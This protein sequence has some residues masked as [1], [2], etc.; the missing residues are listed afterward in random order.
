MKKRILSQ[1]LIPAFILGILSGLSSAMIT[2]SNIRTFVISN[3]Y[4]HVDWGTY[5]QYKSATHAH[6][7]NSDGNNTLASVAERHYELGFHILA[8]TD[9]DVTFTTPDKAEIGAMTSER[10]KEMQNGAGRNGADG[11][12]FIP[13]ANE[14]S[15][16]LSTA[17][18]PRRGQH[19]STY[20]SN[21]QNGGI[22][23][24]LVESMLERLRTEGTGIAR[25]NHI[26]RNTLAAFVASDPN[27]QALNFADAAAKNST[28][29]YVEHYAGLFKNNPNLVG[30]EIINEFDNESQASEIMWDNILTRLMPEGRNVWGFSA[31]DSHTNNNVGWSYDIM[32]MPELSLSELRYAKESGA[33]FGFSR[34]NR[35]YDIYA[36]AIIPEDTRGSS[37]NINRIRET[38][39]LPTP[40]INSITTGINTITINAANYEFINWYSDGILIHSGPT[41]DFASL[42][43]NS[44][45]FGSYVRATVGHSDY[46]VLFTQ[47]FG[48]RES[49][50][51][52]PLPTAQ[53]ITPPSSANITLPWGTNPDEMSLQL[54]G[55][56]SITTTDGI[57]RPAAIIWNLNSINYNPANKSAQTFTITGTVK[58]TGINI[59][60][61]LS[62]NVSVQ[63]TV[64]AYVGL[65]E[66]N[67]QN[68]P[69]LHQFAGSGSSGNST[70]AL[71]GSNSGTRTVNMNSQPRTINITSRGGTSQ[72][73]D[74]KLFALDTTPGYSYKFEFTGRVTSGSGNQNIF[75]NAVSGDSGGGTNVS[76]L[77]SISTAVNSTFT[78]SHSSTHEEIQSYLS[79]ATPVMRYRLGGASSQDLEITGIV[80]TEF[81]TPFIPPTYTVTWNRDG[82]EPAPTQTSVFHGGSIALP[83]AMNRAGYI[84]DGWFMDSGFN[85]VAVF[86]ITNVTNDTTL[87]AKWSRIAVSF[88]RNGTGAVVSPES[89]FVN[90]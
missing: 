69:N 62:P 86:P 76:T 25:L 70:H 5:N 88:N 4:A 20:W 52:L 24:E 18:I 59:P 16:R 27:Q 35:R 3:P 43:N 14:R 51:E 61:N 60:T 8:Y 42:Q 21:I 78:I 17:A 11:M 73:L 66:Y 13:G 6:T 47:P 19:V 80:I 49:G 67:M 90:A 40:Q 29:A 48:I 77:A 81:L 28:Q 55:G 75:I 63:R 7:T 58:P 45:N 36:G 87:W 46:G 34:V 53:I 33:F 82:G 74:I 50:Q 1:I 57:R 26:S 65:S 22:D 56:T 85:T 12:I 72:G 15:Q 39:N 31:D 44:Q 23:S 10:V 89:S 2:P 68:D 30:M 37:A 79:A 64:E 41:I 32:L 83:G 9:H 54:P 71:L 84:F 38:L